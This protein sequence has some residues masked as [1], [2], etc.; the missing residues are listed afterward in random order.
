MLVHIFESLGAGESPGVRNEID[1][2]QT[3]QQLPTK[4][5][6]SEQNE[7]KFHGCFI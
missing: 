3:V 7:A 5:E 4:R 1:M 2:D 6:A